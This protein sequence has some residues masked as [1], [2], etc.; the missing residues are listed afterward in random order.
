MKT[1]MSTMTI[2]ATH[3]VSSQMDDGEADRK[4]DIFLLEDG[5]YLIHMETLWIGATQTTVT[6]L[7]FTASALNML[8]GLFN[9]AVMNMHKWP[10]PLVLAASKD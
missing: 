6:E 2:H 7:R 8:S 9:E 10:L 1:Q 3:G 4:F 5:S